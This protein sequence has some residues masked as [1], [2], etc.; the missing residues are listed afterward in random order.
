MSVRKKLK[1][2]NVFLNS[3]DRKRR[4]GAGIEH[5]TA[6]ILRNLNQSPPLL[7]YSARM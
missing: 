4:E 6:L 1:K 2:V 7:W 3:C 5:F